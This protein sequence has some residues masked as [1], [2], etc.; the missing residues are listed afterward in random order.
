M[1]TFFGTVWRIAG[2]AFLVL[3]GTLAAAGFLALVVNG[4]GSMVT[5]KP[6]DPMS[7]LLAVIGSLIPGFFAMSFFAE[8]FRFWKS[9]AK[10]A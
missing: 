10:N 1:S 7:G 9:Q 2:S 5:D 8:A 6:W 4:A 3:L